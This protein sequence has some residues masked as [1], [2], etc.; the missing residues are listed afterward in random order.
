MAASARRRP[1]GF[2]AAL[3]PILGFAAAVVAVAWELLKWVAGDP[4]RFDSFLGTGISIQHVPPFHLTM[5]SDINLP[6]VWDV[7][8]AFGTVDAAGTPFISSL[9]GS[10]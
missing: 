5:A 6:H 9:I 1:A 3:R 10:A 7:V 4:W 8:G 2:R